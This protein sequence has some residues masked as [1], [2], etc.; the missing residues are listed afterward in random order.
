MQSNCYSD[1]TKINGPSQK[2]KMAEGGDKNGDENPFS[3]KSFVKKKSKSPTEDIDDRPNN[4]VHN[5]QNLPDISARMPHEMP[6]TEG[7]Q[8]V[9]SFTDTVTDE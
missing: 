1:L 9:S 2:T 3:F 7:G 8:T 4:R 5:A 6:G